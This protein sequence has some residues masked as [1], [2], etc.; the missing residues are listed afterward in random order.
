M[1]KEYFIDIAR[2]GSRMI[3]GADLVIKSNKDYQKILNN[4]EKL[5]QCIIES[6]QKYS[7]PLALPYMDL[8]LEK[9]F[10]LNI[11]DIPSEMVEKFQFENNISDTIID[12]VKAKINTSTPRIEAT[13]AAIKY[14]QENSDFLPV[15]M[16]IGPF[17]LYTKLLKDPIT[18]VFLSSMGITSQDEPGIKDM[19]ILL[20]LTTLI[21]KQSISYQIEAGAKAIC[22]CEPAANTVFITPDSLSETDRD[23][24]DKVV[25]DP[26]KQIKSYLSE[27]HVDLILHNCG[28]LNDIM[29]RK[30]CLL[31][32]VILSL[33]SSK[34]LWEYTKVVPDDIV[35]FG[36]LPTKRFMLDNTMPAKK[37]AELTKHIDSEMKK[38]KHPF[39]LGS[40]CDVLS[41]SGY[42]ETIENKVKV[43]L[44]CEC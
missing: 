26:N 14:V 23:I 7:S 43:L 16:C 15:G 11:L 37:V 38:T 6:T 2:K 24:F 20:E 8:K 36:N 3:F 29:V 28:E 9:E 30:M 17:S 12:K 31:E 22:V 34:D 5:G 40:E 10:L 4:G 19:Q 41:V 27:N 32:P 44:G 18:P 13:C 42:E 21:I 1:G 39:I 33:G 35:L 25:M